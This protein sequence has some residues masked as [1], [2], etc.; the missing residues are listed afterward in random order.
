[1]ASRDKVADAEECKAKGN[2]CLKAQD[3]NKAIEWYNEAL[4]LHKS[5]VRGNSNSPMKKTVVADK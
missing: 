4:K 1:M 3:F 5:H 2:E